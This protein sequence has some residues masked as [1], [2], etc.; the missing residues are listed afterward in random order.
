VTDPAGSTFRPSSGL[1]P[2]VPSDFSL[3]LQ[4]NLSAQIL[5]TNGRLYH[6]APASPYCLKTVN[7]RVP[8]LPRNYS[9]STLIQPHP[10]PSHLSTHFPLSTVIEPTLLRKISFRDEEGFSSCQYVLATMLS[11]SPRRNERTF[12]KVSVVHAAFASALKARL[13]GLRTFGATH[14]FTL[15]TA[16]QLAHH[17]KDGFVNG[18]QI[19]GFPHTC[20][21]SYRASYFYPDRTVSC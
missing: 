13:P 12:Q 7:S 14:A 1:T 4:I 10:P 18:L 17:P 3:P 6:F 19:F 9:G 16:W 15:V 20:H 2:P 21:P 8:L 5:Q 11:L